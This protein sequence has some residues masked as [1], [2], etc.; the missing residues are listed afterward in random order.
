MNFK[1]KISDVV[2][3][4]LHVDEVRRFLSATSL[5]MR[6]TTLRVEERISVECVAGTQLF[7]GCRN[8]EGV[9]EKHAEDILVPAE[10]LWDV[11]LDGILEQDKKKEPPRC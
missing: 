3:S 4:A 6:P 11:W 8:R 10:T 9:V 1:Y 5:Q 2:A 7:Y